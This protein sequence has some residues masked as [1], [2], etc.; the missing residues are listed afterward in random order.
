MKEAG[1]TLGFATREFPLGLTQTWKSKTFA[2]QTY[3]GKGIFKT[4]LASYG[5]WARAT[6]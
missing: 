3:D 6:W 5:K 2:I 4:P 1:L